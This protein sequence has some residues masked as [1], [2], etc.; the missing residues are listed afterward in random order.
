V[1]DIVKRALV[2]KRFG[3]KCLST[4]AI[5]SVLHYLL[6]MKLTLILF[7]CLAAAPVS[8]DTCYCVA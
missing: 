5:W 8:A 3:G 2:T 6:G 1:P 4:G 7:A